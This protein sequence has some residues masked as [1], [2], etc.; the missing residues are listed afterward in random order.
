MLTATSAPALADKDDNN[1][2]AKGC[3]NANEKSKVR[4]KNPHCVGGADLEI[5]GPEEVLTSSGRGS[6]YIVTVTNNGPETAENVEVTVTMVCNDQTCEIFTTVVV[7][8]LM[9]FDGTL[10]AGDS[11]WFLVTVRSI[12]FSVGVISSVTSD[13]DDPNESNNSLTTNVINCRGL[14]VGLR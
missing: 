13:T 1:G 2:K 7:K 12:P 3:E 8:P 9:N 10:D 14:C 6:I 11:K 4:E 5:T